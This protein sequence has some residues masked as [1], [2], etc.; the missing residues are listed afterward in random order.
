MINKTLIINPIITLAM[1]S[2]VPN[3]VRSHALLTVGDVIRGNK[4]GQDD[5]SVMTLPITS[6]PRKVMPTTPPNDNGIMVVDR[7]MVDRIMRTCLGRE[8][9]FG[10]RSGAAYVLQV[11]RFIYGAVH[12]S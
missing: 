7:P 3:S 8:S 1:T 9:E 2:T 10:V 4:S 5:V 12:G 11:F 6:I